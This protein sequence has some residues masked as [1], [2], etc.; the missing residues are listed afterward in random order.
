MNIP[1]T[2][3]ASNKIVVS[4]PRMVGILDLNIPAIKNKIKYSSGNRIKI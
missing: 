3:V 2:A 1:A 4:I